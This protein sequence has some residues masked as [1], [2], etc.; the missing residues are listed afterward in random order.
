MTLFDEIEDDLDDIDDDVRDILGDVEDIFDEYEDAMDTRDQVSV[1]AANRNIALLYQEQDISPFQAERIEELTDAY[2]EQSGNPPYFE[3]LPD[4]K[5]PSRMYD[6]DDIEP[7]GF[8]ERIGY[9]I[10]G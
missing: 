7:E 4:D 6:H 8:L 2:L 10:L 1:A 5:R 3:N 9:A